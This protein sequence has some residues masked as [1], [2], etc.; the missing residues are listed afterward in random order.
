MLTIPI[1][2]ASAIESREGDAGRDWLTAL[3]LA[4]AELCER[5]SLTINGEPRHGHLALVV[6]VRRDD[7]A[8]VLKLSWQ[9]ADT[10]HEARAL[11]LWNGRSMVRLLESAPDLGAL[12][13]ER[14]DAGRTLFDLP[15][16]DAITTAGE[17]LRNLVMPGDASLPK[18]TAH[19]SALVHS[20][21]QRWE[22]LGQPFPRRTLD[23][24]IALAESL[25]QGTT[26]TMVNWDLHYGNILHSSDRNEWVA[27]DPKATIGDPES[28]VAQLFWTRISD[29]SSRSAFHDHLD[30]L[31][32]AAALDRQLATDWTFLRVVDF[33]LW[34]LGMS[35]NHDPGGCEI[36]VDWLA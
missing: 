1:A 12:L 15:M 10:V 36:L 26:S 34:E 29:V 8:C 16:N 28:G 33:W 11:A 4:V 2:F 13:L 21:P 3:P 35:L 27:I 20:L 18:A 30:A 9:D 25:S 17:M 32:E 23:R 24:T 31:I 6:P 7:E 19:A 14:L 22:E 5:W